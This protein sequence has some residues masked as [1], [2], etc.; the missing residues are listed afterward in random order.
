MKYSSATM[1]SP[2]RVSSMETNWKDKEGNNDQM[3]AALGS[4]RITVGRM[5][6]PTTP[7]VQG[8]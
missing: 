6:T 1:R 5:L 2:K 8:V 7:N 4:C 3:S